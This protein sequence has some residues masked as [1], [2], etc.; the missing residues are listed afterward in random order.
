MLEPMLKQQLK[1]MHVLEL[2]L[3]WPLGQWRMFNEHLKKDDVS[4]MT[5][6][7]YGI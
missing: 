2:N 4:H 6:G 5:C 3:Q 1:T 7:F